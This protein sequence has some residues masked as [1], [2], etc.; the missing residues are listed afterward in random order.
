MRKE[1]AVAQAQALAASIELLGTGLRR[2]IRQV[3]AMVGPDAV[4]A[5]AAEYRLR[6]LTVVL[7]P[8]GAEVYQ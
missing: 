5:Y 7:R 8:W 2:P 4:M 6:G 1:R 3:A